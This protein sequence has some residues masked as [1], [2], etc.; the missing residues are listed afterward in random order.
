MF[1]LFVDSASI[2]VIDLGHVYVC[3]TNC[4]CRYG[5]NMCLCVV[6][7]VIR[8]EERC[9]GREELFSCMFVLFVDSASIAVIDLGHVY[10]CRTNCLCR[11]GK[12]MF[13][14]VVLHVFLFFL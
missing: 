8:S 2:A 9:V 12:N 6:F 14:C 10:V 4:L 7:H 11:Y 1:V 5:K 3:R 13:L